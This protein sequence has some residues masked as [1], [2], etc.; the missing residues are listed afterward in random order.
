MSMVIDN[1]IIIE[2]FSD[3]PTLKQN[4]LLKD[5]GKVKLGTDC[6]EILRLRGDASYQLNYKMSHKNKFFYS[7]FF[8]TKTNHNY[9]YA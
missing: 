4:N 1:K 8:V 3:L 6:F 9:C 2:Y 5:L 7:H